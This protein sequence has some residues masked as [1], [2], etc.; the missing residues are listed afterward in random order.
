MLSPSRLLQYVTLRTRYSELMTLNSQYILFISD[1]QRRLEA[2]EVRTPP[3][4]APAAH[5]RRAL[6]WLNHNRLE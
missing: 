3:R 1:T 4:R 2:E 5:R 6:V